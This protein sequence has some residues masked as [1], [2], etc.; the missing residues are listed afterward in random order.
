MNQVQQI[1]CPVDFLP[2]S[3]ATRS[4]RRLPSRISTMHVSRRSMCSP[5]R[6]AADLFAGLPE[7]QPFRL[8]DRHRAHLLEH[9]KTFA[10]SEGAASRRMNFAI[11][12]GVDVDAEILEAAEQ[13]KPD[14][15]VMGTHGRS[16][17]QHL[18]LGS[19]AVK[20]CCTRRAVRCSLCSQGAGRR[21]RRSGALRTDSVWVR[22][23]RI[24]R[25]P[26]SE[27]ATSLASRSGAH[28]DVL[29]VVQLLPMYEMTGAVPPYLPGTS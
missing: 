1:L 4:T 22:F 27:H 17:F 25:W 5:K 6:F 12:E 8:T 10:T 19:V 13:M 18:M 3:R 9:L 29:S 20:R 21:S 15:I 2:T 26:R 14:L 24:A 23:F 16:G 11:R 7:F 28:L